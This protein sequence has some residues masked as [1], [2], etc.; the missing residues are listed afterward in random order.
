MSSSHVH[1]LVLVHGM[2]GNPSHLSELDR[3]MKQAHAEPLIDDPDNVTLRTL[4]AKTNKDESTYDGVDWGGERVTEE[5]RCP[6]MST[7]LA[8]PCSDI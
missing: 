8:H 1:L 3:V 7:P 6:F 4:V 5:V 2:W